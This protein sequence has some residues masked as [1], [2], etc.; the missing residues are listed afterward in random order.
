FVVVVGLSILWIVWISDPGIHR[1]SLLVFHRVD[2]RYSC[3]MGSGLRVEGSGEC[4]RVVGED[5]SGDLELFNDYLAYLA[6][7]CYSPA[8]V[9]AYAFD[10]LHFARWLASE[11]VALEAVDTDT[12]LRYLAACR[13]T[14]L[15]GQHDNVISLESGRSVGFAP[16]T[17]NRRLAAISGLFS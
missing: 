10:L 13:T 4:W 17:I 16:A 11:Q 6:D 2:V 7:R 14:R 1:L 5:R 8:S 12:L 9:R 15:S 3:P